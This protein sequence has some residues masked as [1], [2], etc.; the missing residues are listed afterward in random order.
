RGQSHERG[1]N[2]NHELRCQLSDIVC[3]VTC[4]LGG[5]QSGICVPNDKGGKAASVSEMAS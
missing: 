3:Q 5:Q 1:E 4:F 2:S